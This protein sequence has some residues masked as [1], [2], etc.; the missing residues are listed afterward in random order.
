MTQSLIA[1]RHDGVTNRQLTAN[2]GLTIELDEVVA[3]REPEGEVTFL[4][5]LAQR[6]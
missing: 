3:M 2:S 4:W 6:R 1:I 5:V